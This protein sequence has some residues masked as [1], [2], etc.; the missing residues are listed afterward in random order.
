M[1]NTRM[2]RS[3]LKHILSELRTARLE[4]CSICG[5][6]VKEL[7]A[8]P[9]TVICTW[10]GC[11][12]HN[13]IWK[14]TV[15]YKAKLSKI[16]IL[17]IFE[18]WM[19][20][21]SINDISFVL[22]LSSREIVWS[23]LKKVSRYLIPN[24]EKAECMIGG[25]DIIVEVDESKFGKRKYNRGHRV[26]G[27]W[28]LGMVERTA[29]RKIKLFVVDDRSKSTLEEKLKN[30]IDKESIVFTDG[31]KGY[32]GL[33]A[34]FSMHGV[35]NHSLG[36][37]DPSTGIHTNTI[38]GCWSGIKPSVALRGRTKDKINLYLIRFMLLRNESLPPLQALLKYLF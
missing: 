28:I 31:W 26:D 25:R 4:K 7:Q 14:N 20:K 32:T 37:K 19:R 12:A 10:R 36:F 9:D 6:K 30:S 23:I 2:R 16:K 34:I 3:E 38:E 22:R 35:V 29:E 5:S 11:K 15:F 1:T 17:Q 33:G 21:M 8:K 18:L 27:V 13:S 24:Y